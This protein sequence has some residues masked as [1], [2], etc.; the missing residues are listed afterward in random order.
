[1][2]IL[3]KINSLREERG[4]SVYKLAEESGVTQSTLANMFT[5]QTLPSITT[6]E[7]ICAAFGITMS[8]FFVENKEDSHSS[9]EDELLLNFRDLSKTEKQ[10]VIGLVKALRGEDNT[11]TI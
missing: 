5:R 4:W 8:R 6:L 1:M 7:N 2:D 10:A 9:E 3:K 11:K